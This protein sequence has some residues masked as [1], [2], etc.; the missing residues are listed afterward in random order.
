MSSARIRASSARS[1]QCFGNIASPPTFQEFHTLTV[2]F[3]AAISLLLWNRG[4]SSEYGGGHNVRGWL[5]QN[6]V[7]LAILIVVIA[8]I[9]VASCIWLGILKS[10]E[11]RGELL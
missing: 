10:F 1:R 6:A 2:I 9:N 11:Q 5:E 3:M 7:A 4:C 8:F